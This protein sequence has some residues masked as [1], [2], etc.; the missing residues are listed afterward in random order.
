M[1][2]P[3]LAVRVLPLTLL[4]DKML[5]STTQ[6]LGKE[7]SSII[8]HIIGLPKKTQ[9]NAVGILINFIRFGMSICGLPQK[10]DD[11]KNQQLFVGSKMNI[12]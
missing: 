10:S 11:E 12:E 7:P 2:L 8:W 1:L 5:S 6:L 9:R 3:S 4:R